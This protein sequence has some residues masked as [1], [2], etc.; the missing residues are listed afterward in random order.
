METAT[1]EGTIYCDACDEECTTLAPDPADAERMLCPSCHAEQVAEI[2]AE[3][4]EEAIAAAT[5]E[6]D[7]AE[8]ELETLL[9]DL[10]EIKQRIVEVRHALRMARKRLAAAQ[11]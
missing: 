1:M 5:D 6:V 4:R 10:R 3:R 2:E 9:D 7:E 8:Y 11:K